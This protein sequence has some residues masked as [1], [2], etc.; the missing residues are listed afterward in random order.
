MPPPRCS[1]QDKI[2]YRD[3]LANWT[4]QPRPQYSQKFL[5]RAWLNSRHVI[6]QQGL[7]QIRSYFDYFQ[8]LYELIN[9]F[10]RLQSCGAYWNHEQGQSDMWHRTFD[11]ALCRPDRNR[12]GVDPGDMLKVFLAGV[13]DS[14]A[15]LRNLSLTSF[16]WG[17]LVWDGKDFPAPAYA[18]GRAVEHLHYL[19][20]APLTEAVA[21][22]NDR[23]PQRHVAK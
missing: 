20:L 19:C 23:D 16:D 4:N 5:D 6:Q 18:I 17:N 15:K 10:P 9:D 1:P 7:F 8:I 12:R 22:V 2:A 3:S 21:A 11:R 14:Q 13:A